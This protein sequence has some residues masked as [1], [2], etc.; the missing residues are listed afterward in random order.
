MSLTEAQR[1]INDIIEV[2]RHLVEG[3]CSNPGNSGRRGANY[4]ANHEIHQFY[5]GRL[6]R[7]FPQLDALIITSY[8]PGQS[9]MNRG[10][11]S[12]SYTMVG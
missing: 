5:Y 11:Q 8:A 6:F 10:C 7:I 3:R 12:T 2:V 9:A 4:Y 1:H